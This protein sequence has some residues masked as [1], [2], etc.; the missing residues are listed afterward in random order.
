MVNSIAAKGRQ[1]RPQFQRFAIIVYL[2]RLISCRFELRMGVEYL[3]SWD[4]CSVSRLA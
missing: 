4:N 2:L 3:E 1:I